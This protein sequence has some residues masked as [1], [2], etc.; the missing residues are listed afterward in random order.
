[1]ICGE[2]ADRRRR[3][4]RA[5]ILA[6]LSALVAIHVTGCGYAFAPPKPPPPNVVVTIQPAA[7]SL[8][9]GQTQAFQATVTGD[10]DTNVT[11]EVNAVAGG[12]ASIG[13]ISATGLFTAPTVLPPGASVTVTAVSQVNPKDSASVTV[14]LKDNLSISIAPTSAT[15]SVSATQLFTATVTAGS[16]S[17]STAVTWT[18]NGIAGGNSTVG[19]IVASNSTA[20]LYMAPVATPTPPTVTVTATSV[21]DTTKS[22]SAS[23]TIACSGT[24]SISPST[25]NVALGLTQNFAATFCPP[26]TVAIVWD[27][28]GIPGGNATLGTILST[29]AN[30][31]QYTAP[32][33]LPANNPVTVHAVAGVATVSATVTIVSNVSVTVAPSATSVPINERV[34]LTPTVTNTSNAAV[35]WSVNGTANGNTILGQICQHAVIPCAAPTGPA[36]GSIDFLAPA[37]VPTSN[38]VT[39]TATSAAD[40]T[41]SGNAI[42]IIT[43]ATGAVAVSISPPFAFIAPSSATISQQRFYATVTGSSNTGVT[44]TVQS[45]VPGQ[46][47]SGAGCGSVD[48]TGLYSAPTVAPSPNAISVI[49]ASVADATKSATATVAVNSGPVIEVILPSSVMAGAVESFPFTL[50]GVNFV[51]GSGSA[52]S[53]ILINGTPR[54]TTCPSASTCST[55]LNPSDVQS[56]ATLTIEIQNPPPLSPLSNP[57]PFVIVPYDVSVG[58]ITLSAGQPAS[59]GTNIIVTEPT[60][61]AASAPINVDFFGPLTGGNTCEIQASPITITRPASGTSTVSLCVHGNLLDPTFTYVFTGPPGGDIPVTASAITGLFPNTIELDLQISSATLPGVRTL[62]ITTLNNDR[63]AAT[64]MIEVQ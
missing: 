39:V 44:W 62:F 53:S 30:T 18:V 20:A 8:F 64:A 35:T 59:T 33:S 32:T 60:T 38:P 22:A 19:T 55:A 10:T 43:G 7:A 1:M 21:A 24:N 17:P 31:A 48:A 15:V 34:T 40:P 16:G 11:W 5:G 49:A 27:A 29:S 2:N 58:V 63:A 47:C 41:R 54:A 36:A 26:A 25:T 61:A 45:A 13:T 6:A 42:V 56:A 51:A 3:I 46:G 12:S 52:A 9:L 4:F 57:V 28:N 23:V 50:E 37:T 14:T